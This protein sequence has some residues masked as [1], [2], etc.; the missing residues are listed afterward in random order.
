MIFEHQSKNKKILLAV[1]AV[2]LLGGAFYFI[3]AKFIHQPEPISCTMEA[4]LCPDGSAVGRTGPNCEFAPCPQI[5]SLLS[6]AEA[7]AIAEK[8]C[9][10]GGE[11]LSSGIYNK[12]SETWWF[13]ANLNSTR[14]GCNPACVVDEKTKTA[15][16]NWRCTGV[17][18]I[19]PFDSGVEGIVTLGPTCPVMREG[20]TSCA[21]KPYATT[22]QVIVLGSPKS[23]PFATVESD[24]DGRYKIMLPPGEYAIQPVGGSSLPRCETKN[25][26]IEPSKIIKANLSCDTGIR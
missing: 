13:D 1:F 8:S 9:I 19:L 12:N 4:K 6:E 21:D 20:D 25:I 18:G 23:S 17:S 2:L 5:N 22:I 3:W 14:E 15:E 16:I 11:A 7:R 10:K 26:T 24:K